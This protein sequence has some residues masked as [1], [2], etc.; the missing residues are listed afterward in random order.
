MKTISVQTP[1][2]LYDIQN[3][4]DADPLLTMAAT[5]I[6]LALIF[7]ARVLLTRR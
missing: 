5:W 6:V 4:F 2:I 3:A 1:G 7:S